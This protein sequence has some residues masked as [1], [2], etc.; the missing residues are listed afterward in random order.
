MNNDIIKN[1]NALRKMGSNKA[2]DWLIDQY[3]IENQNWG[4]AIAIIPHL[5]WQR[6]DQI[7][8][9]SYYLKKI[10]YATSKPYEAFAK[11]MK[12]QLLVKILDKYIPSDVSGKKLL[13]YYLIG[14][15]RNAAKTEE[16]TNAIDKL[17]D[18]LETR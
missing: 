16:D 4:E 8:L 14:V 2:A 1:I 18:K 9:A 7:K 3:S 15:L 11:I 5:S 12:I 10:P 17:L 6:A 13:A